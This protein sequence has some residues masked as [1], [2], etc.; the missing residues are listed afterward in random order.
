MINNKYYYYMITNSLFNK[1]NTV[2]RVCDKYKMLLM[3]LI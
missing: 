3:L 2:N 1:F